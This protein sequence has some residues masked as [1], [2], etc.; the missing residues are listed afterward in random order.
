[1]FRHLQAQGFWGVVYVSDAGSIT[2]CYM[3]PPRLITTHHTIP[4]L[5][6]ISSCEVRL[7][8]FAAEGD[9]FTTVRVVRSAVSPAFVPALMHR[10]RTTGIC[11][12]VLVE[13]PRMESA[14][15]HP[16]MKGAT[17]HARASVN[18]RRGNE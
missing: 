10:R 17:K 14:S 11:W 1:M 8:R 5:G 12:P 3:K 7:I 15:L 18:V 2:L 6:A 16:S 4:Q 13:E 9:A